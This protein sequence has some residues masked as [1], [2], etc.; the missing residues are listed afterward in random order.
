MQVIMLANT[1]PVGRLLPLS[2]LSMVG[3]HM[4]TK[5]Y[6]A[7][8]KRLVLKATSPIRGFVKTRQ[9]DEPFSSAF[10]AL[11]LVITLYEIVS[12]EGGTVY[13]GEGSAHFKV[14]FRVVV[15]RPFN[16]EILEGTLKRADKTGLYV[17]IGFFS[18][19]FV[20]EQLREEKATVSAED[21]SEEHTSELQSP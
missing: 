5:V 13:P 16:G 2:T 6:M 9:D 21:R 1:R 10:T 7:P 14:E 4:K 8:S 12:I 15:F 3:T 19:I 11:G 20:P 18:D 17:D